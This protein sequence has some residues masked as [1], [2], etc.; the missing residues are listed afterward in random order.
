MVLS[1][2][3]GLSLLEMDLGRAHRQI[4]EALALSQ[5]LGDHRGIAWTL[6]TY[7]ALLAAAERWDEAATVWGAS[8]ELMASVGASLVPGVSW[9]RERYI[10]R[11]QAALSSDRFARA[12]D[13]GRGL[14]LGGAITFAKSCAATAERNA[15]RA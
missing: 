12:H 11:A 15:P 4:D 13:T 10:G 2:S 9:L 14:S 6:D 7:A 3:A 5:T 1:S 8:D